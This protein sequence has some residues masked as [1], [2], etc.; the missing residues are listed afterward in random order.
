MKVLETLRSLNPSGGS[1][2]V[3]TVLGLFLESAPAYLAQIEQALLD[4]DAHGLSKAAHAL[5]SSSANTGAET[6]AAYY[7]QLEQLG[8]AGRMEE[9]RLLFAPARE[10]HE[11]A[12]ERIREILRGAR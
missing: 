3:A 10:E 6:L 4:A 9:A 1:D 7:Q 11:R 12:V 2:L 5:K 8:R